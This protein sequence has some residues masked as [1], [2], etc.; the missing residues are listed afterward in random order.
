MSQ[1]LDTQGEAHEALGTAVASYG[2]RVLSD[3]HTLGNLVADLHSLAC[4][5]STC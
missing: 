3:P 1:Q 5:C 2:Q 4:C